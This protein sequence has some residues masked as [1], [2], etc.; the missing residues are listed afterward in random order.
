[1][2]QRNPQSNRVQTCTDS[3]RTQKQAEVVHPDLTSVYGSANSP[4]GTKIAFICWVM[5]TIY[6]SLVKGNFRN[7]QRD[8][9]F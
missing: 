8:N 9:A 1:M 4:V 5:S 6:L 2:H 3:H 7:S